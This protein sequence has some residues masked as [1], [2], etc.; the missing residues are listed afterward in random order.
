MYRQQEQVRRNSEF[1]AMK[2]HTAIDVEEEKLYAARARTRGDAPQRPGSK[3]ARSW[4]DIS[5]TTSEQLNVLKQKHADLVTE[6]RAA[7]REERVRLLA[8]VALQASF[9]RYLI[10][11]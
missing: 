4:S 10:Q 7:E 5:G 1:E 3:R 8:I 6:T 11:T 2:V 9:R